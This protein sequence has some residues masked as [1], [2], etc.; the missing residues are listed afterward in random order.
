MESLIYSHKIVAIIQARIGSTRFPGKVLADVVGKPLIL[1][2][3]N[4]FRCSKLIDQYVVAIPNNSEDDYLSNYLSA[5]GVELFRG[6]SDDVLDR[7]HQ[8]AIRYKAS[9]IVRLTS[10]CPLHSGDTIDE[11]ISAFLK[12]NIDYAANRLPYSRP[13]GQDVEV[14]NFNTLNLAAIQATSKCDREHVTPWMIRN[15]NIT[16]LLVKHKESG[17]SIIASKMRWTVDYPEDLEFVSNVWKLLDKNNIRTPN[18]YEILRVTESMYEKKSKRIPNEGYLIS[19]FNEANSDFALPLK[20]IKSSTLSKVSESLIPGGAQTYSKSWKQHIRGVSPEFLDHGKGA[21]VFDVDGNEYVDLIQGLLPNILGYAHPTVD[22]AAYD[23]AKSGHSF[24]MPHPLEIELAKRLVEIIPCAE[25]VRF[26]KNGSDATAGAIRVAR[27]F[28]GKERVAVCGY[29][30]WQDWFIGST[31]RYFGVP[32]CV[33]EL[34]HPFTYNNLDELDQLLSKYPDEFA[35]VIME[36][37]NFYWPSEG[38]LN[39]VKKLTHKH[40][41]L[42]IFDEICSGFHFGLGG[43]QK[44]FGVIPDMA[45][46]GKAMGNG[47]P[48]S[49][50][51]GRK[52]VMKTF[53]EA[54]VSFTFAGDVSAIA[55]S[56]TV[57]DILQHTDAYEKMNSAGEQLFNGMKFFAKLSGLEDFSIIGH[58]NWPLFSFKGKVHQGENLELKA[59]WLQEVTRRGV[60]V[61]A[62]HNISAALTQK[63]VDKVLTAYA[64]AF[65]VI[66]SV[67]AK[68]LNPMDFLEGSIPT[69]AFKARG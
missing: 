23:R 64:H 13:D 7:Y 55:A 43:A 46:F 35:A 3:L 56:I 10:D 4:Q 30:G 16:K 11:V 31:S 22:K 36:P 60:L 15:K 44:L 21:N 53:D 25:M 57:L 69:A 41:A 28:T 37:F 58:H 24:S 27:A 65:K 6:S 48:I 51:V 47:Y 39:E 38:Y 29:H 54:F 66:Q 63:D 2:A 40:K 62:T 68:N 5:E 9:V 1:R 45:C 18:Y 17:S 33:R 59:L 8:A 50:V 14:F 34:A 12:N 20:I 26:G 42:L 19:I 61:I 32:N 52:D 67:R 49:A